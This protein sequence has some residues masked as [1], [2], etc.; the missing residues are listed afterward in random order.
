[1]KHKI[2]PK[3]ITFTM[4][5]KLIDGHT[6]TMESGHAYSKPCGN[7][8]YGDRGNFTRIDSLCAIKTDYNPPFV[9]YFDLD[10]Q[11]VTPIWDKD[12]LEVV[13]ADWNRI[14]DY[15]RNH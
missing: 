4:K 5:K 7:D 14:N 11:K 3:G 12:T 13:S 2:A 1:M 6:H 8:H 10:N 15:F 9:I